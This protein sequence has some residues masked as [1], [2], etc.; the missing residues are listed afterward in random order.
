MVNKSSG[1]RGERFP[2]LA[3]ARSDVINQRHRDPSSSQPVTCRDRRTF[4]RPSKHTILDPRI[5]TELYIGKRRE[6]HAEAARS[7]FSSN[8]Y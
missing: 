4:N 8:V 5:S 2:Q 1:Q 7:S 6:C 3:R